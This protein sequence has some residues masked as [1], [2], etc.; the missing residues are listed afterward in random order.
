M[1]PFRELE[2]VVFPSTEKT[3]A[4]LKD[5]TYGGA[6]RY[7]VTN[8]LG[9]NAGVTE[10]TPGQGQ[11]IQFIEKPADGSAVIPGIQSEQL[12]LILVDR[13]E[14]LNAKFPCVENVEM[15]TLL[16]GILN[17]SRK[18]VEDRIARNVMGELKK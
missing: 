15:I 13:T 10:Y 3:I 1:D 18:R 17:L 6:H 7:Y 4:V 12:I 8:C 14:K 5:D 11:V 2:G 9:H 16:Q